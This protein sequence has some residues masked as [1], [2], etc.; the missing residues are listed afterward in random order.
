M[1]D[2][3]KPLGDNVLVKVKKQEKRTKSGIVLPDTADDEKPQIGEVIAVGTDEK[4]I[5]V[6][7][8]DKIIFAKYSGSEIKIDEE[9]YLILKSEDILAV[10]E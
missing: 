2:K 7:A 9:E 1:T 5:Q 3:I 10:V 4:K 6:K 8:G